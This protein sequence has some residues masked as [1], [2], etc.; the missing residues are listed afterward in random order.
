MKILIVGAS[1]FIGL[2]FYKFLIE[3]SKFNIAGTYFSNKKDDNFL[4]LDMTSKVDIERILQ[5]TKPDAIVWVA[6]NKNLKFCETDIEEAKK[7]NTY[8]IID[9][10]DILDS[11]TLK[12]HLVYISTDYVFDGM[13]GN[14]KS[15]DKPKPT[16]NYGISK[17]LA[18]V[19]IEN[20]YNNFSIV[21]TSAVMGNGSTFFDWIVSELKQ[22]KIIELFENSFFT[23]TPIEFLSKNIT[24][25]IINKKYGVFHI[26]GSQKLSRFGFGILLKALSNEFIA[27]AKPFVL[28]ENSSLFQK[29]LSMIPSENLIINNQEFVSYLKKEM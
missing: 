5:D 29:D 1:S 22:D 18:E 15:S 4:Q 12:P 21:R 19:A 25:L 8:P 10:L 11:S 14:Y 13:C 2:R 17:Y 20:K 9:L 24:D 6:G 28:D 7:I 23:P 3:N 26:C 16:T 27:T